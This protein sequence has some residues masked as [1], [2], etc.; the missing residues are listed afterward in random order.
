MARTISRMLTTDWLSPA[1]NALLIGWMVETRTGL[2]TGLKRLRAGLPAD[3]KAGD[4]TG[5]TASAD[6]SQPDRYNDIAIAWPPSKPPIIITAY[7]ESPVKSSNMR[8]EDQVVLAQVGTIAAQ[9]V[10]TL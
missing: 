6:I 9:W 3:W 7:Y 1:S 5:T 4:K 8:D 2:K 10:T